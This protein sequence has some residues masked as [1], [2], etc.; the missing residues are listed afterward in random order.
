MGELIR[1]YG[2]ALLACV[3][4]IVRLAR[5]RRHRRSTTSRMG[6]IVL[7]AIALSLT[8]KAPAIYHAVSVLT[9]IPN[10]GR[11]IDHTCILVA[12]WG[13]LRILLHI[14]HPDEVRQRSLPHAVWIALAFTGMCLLFAY[15]D[16]PVDAVRFAGR[17]GRTPGVLEYWLVYLAG[18]LPAYLN[19]AWLAARYAGMATDS[20]VRLGLGLISAGTLCSVAYHIHKGLFFAARRFGIHYPKAVSMPL[21][22]YLTLAAAILVLIGVAL[23]NWRTPAVVGTYRKLLRLRPLWLALYRVNPQIAL[24]PPRS[25]PLELLDVRD[26][27]LR[28]YRRV[29]E[30]RDGRLALRAHLDP[31]VAEAARAAA[32]GSGLTEQKLDALVEATTL[33]SAIQAAQAGSAPPAD[34]SPVAASGGR[35]LA[36]DIAFLDDVAMAYR[37]VSR[38][39][40]R[41]Q[42]RERLQDIARAGRR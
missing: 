33:Y 29:V 31:E 27:D 6:W 35:D 40:L 11:L 25:L 26:L 41:S 24:V 14:N 34:S 28:L 21:D 4:I 30:I 5:H 22:R 23:P 18:M 8:V 39:R 1:H 16:T 32:A 3:V 7:L 20:A 12:G 36:G 19:I 37:Y 42:L 15:A 9:G 17:Y 38:Q 2:P 13:A 10:I